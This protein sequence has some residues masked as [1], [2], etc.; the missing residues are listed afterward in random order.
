MAALGLR[1]RLVSG[2][3]AIVGMIAL[4]ALCFALRS[5]GPAARVVFFDYLPFEELAIAGAAA[6]LGASLGP[7]AARGLRLLPLRAAARPRLRLIGLA[8]LLSWIALPQLR[9][10][11]ASASAAERDAWA[12][13][14]VRHYAA[15]TRVVA[16]VPEVQ[17]DVGRV[18]A[19][20][21]TGGDAHRFARE[22]NGDD[23]LFVLEVVG[24]RGRG[25]FHADCT[26]DDHRVYGWNPGRWLSR[27]REQRIDAVPERVP[28]AP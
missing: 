25:V 17:R 5:V 28:G 8:L 20:A 19:I 16:A 6:A 4:P 15:L 23:M 21:P 26:L 14:R 24:E 27:G 18:V 11:P 9:A 2:L 22:M 3:A 1:G 12:R 10:F 7:P 13:A